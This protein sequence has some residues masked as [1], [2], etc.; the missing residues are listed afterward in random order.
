M[1][2]SYNKLWK[3]LIDRGMNKTALREATGLSPATI[4]KLSKNKPVMVDVLE[5]ICSVL[6]CDIGDI[7]EY[8]PE[9]K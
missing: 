1:S 3:L 5:K 6:G 4:A 8:I 7:C 2:V 9:D